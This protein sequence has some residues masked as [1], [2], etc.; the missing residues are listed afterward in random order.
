MLTNIILENLDS[1]TS[2]IPGV[3]RIGLRIK[4]DD[5]EAYVGK[6][7]GRSRAQIVVRGFMSKKLQAH[8]VK[9]FNSWIENWREKTRSM[10]LPIFREAKEYPRRRMTFELAFNAISRILWEKCN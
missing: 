1:G 2:L 4:T 10:F 5:E 3:Q 9:E 7:T 6:A 8:V